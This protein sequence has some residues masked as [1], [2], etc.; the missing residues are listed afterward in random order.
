[1]L[2]EGT[3]APEFPSGDFTLKQ[4]QDHHRVIVVFEP[5]DGYWEEMATHQRQYEERD[6]VV[7]AFVKSGTVKFQSRPGFVHVL[8]DADEVCRAY[9]ALEGS[10][11]FYLIGKDGGI[12]LARHGIPKSDEIFTLIDMMPMRRKEMRERE[13]L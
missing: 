11:L 6:L 1:L 9:D 7:L 5:T 8:T 13:E 4:Y 3:Q 2:T 12:K 10:T